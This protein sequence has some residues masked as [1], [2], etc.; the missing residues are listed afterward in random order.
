MSVHY[1]QCQL[2]GISQNAAAW[3]SNYVEYLPI[4]KISIVIVFV[5]L[6]LLSVSSSKHQRDSTGSDEEESHVFVLLEHTM[7]AIE[8]FL[9]RKRKKLKPS[10]A[11]SCNTAPLEVINEHPVLMSTLALLLHSNP[12][13]FSERYI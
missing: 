8:K 2:Q 4:S 3:W 9:T 6:Q 11:T 1:C 7:T 10:T 13:L 12:Q 5:S